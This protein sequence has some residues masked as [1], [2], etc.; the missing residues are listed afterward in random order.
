VVFGHA[1]AAELMKTRR[2][3][4]GSWLALFLGKRRPEQPESTEERWG[5]HS[6]TELSPRRAMI[7]GAVLGMIG[8]GLLVSLYQVVTSDPGDPVEDQSGLGEDEVLEQQISAAE[9]LAL[10][11]LAESDP[12][13]R[14]QWVRH[15]DQVRE[16]MAQWSESVLRQPGEIERML[17]HSDAGDRLVTCFVVKQPDGGVRLLEVVDKGDGPRVDWDAYARHC[18]ADWPA[19]IEGRVE[20]AEVRVSASPGTY[21]NP[22]FA[23]VNEWTCFQLTSPDLPGRIHAYARKGTLREARMRAIILGSPKYRQHMT[24]RIVRREGPDGESLFEIERALAI[25]WVRGEADVEAEWEAAGVLVKPVTER[26]EGE[27]IDDW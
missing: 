25:G 22:P 7:A 24:L 1:A 27:V 23:D 12:E 11:F 5:K 14:L 4:Q 10:T 17:G 21:H 2:N 3:R 16:H 26:N 19:I 8:V 13:Q 18:S 15:P 6:K 9:K 20:R